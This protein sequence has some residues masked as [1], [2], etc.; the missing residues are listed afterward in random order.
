VKYVGKNYGQDS[1]NELQNKITVILVEP[2]HTGDLLT[3]HGVRKVMIRNGQLNTQRA[4]K[5]Q[6]KI[7]RATVD[8]GKDM[9]APM[10]LEIL[11]YEIVQG[12]FAINIEVPMELMTLRK[13][14]SVMSDKPIEN[15]MPI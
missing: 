13:P 5:A 8:K 7:I 6:E 15:V 3:R 2:V 4:L 14:S 10:N 9:D 12:Q 1:S 11:Q